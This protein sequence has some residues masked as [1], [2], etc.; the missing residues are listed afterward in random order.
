M[1]ASDLKIIIDGVFFQINPTGI[2]RVWRSILTTWQDTGFAQSLIVIDRGQTAP[3]IAGITYYEMPLYDYREIG[4]DCKHL[5]E[6]CDRHGADLF[7]STYFT[8]P[9]RTPSILM[10]HDMIPEVLEFDLT[11]ICWQEKH[12]AILYA[13]HYMAVSQNTANDL[14]CF[15]HHIKPEQIR[16]IYNGVDA[17]FQPA[18]LQEIEQIKSKLTIQKP[19]FLLVGSRMSLQGYKNAILFFKAFHQLINKTNFE[20]VCVGGD[21][22]LEPVLADFVQGITVH[23]VRLNDRELRAIYSGAIALVYPSRYEGF[24]LPIVE[25]MACGCPVITCCNSSLPEVAGKAAIYVDEQNEAEML[26]ALQQVQLLEIRIPLIQMGL[27]QAKKF[28]W[29]KMAD[30]MMKFCLEI[31]L[32]LPKQATAFDLL[33]QD[34]RHTYIDLEKNQQRLQQLQSYID[35]QSTNLQQL[36]QDKQVLSNQIQQLEEEIQNSLIIRELLKKLIKQ[37]AHKWIRFLLK[38]RELFYY[39]I[40]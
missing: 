4:Q 12:R 10:V 17:Q 23:F 26:W 13:N 9:L 18:S 2:A 7:I 32:N 31:A 34:F 38:F 5:Q 16:V 28:S 15:Y 27:D 3:R 35:T 11:E 20:I 39:F 19:Y 14:M 21:S 25:A 29:E 37:L 22:Q 33:W 1:L 36:Q 24:G 30:D 8:T 6:I 40:S